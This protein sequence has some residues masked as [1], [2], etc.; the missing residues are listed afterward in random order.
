MV[1]TRSSSARPP[2]A[3]RLGGGFGAVRAIAALTA[4]AA[5]AGCSAETIVD[6]SVSQTV[7][8]D[9]HAM[10]ADEAVL[11]EHGA[12][13]FDLRAEPD[14][15]QFKDQLRC[16]GLDPFASTLEIVRLDAPGLESMLDFQL[17][18]APWPNGEWTP[19]A[20]LTDIVVDRGVVPFNDGAFTLWLEGL[21]VLDM[22]SLGDAPAYELR[23]SAQVPYSVDDLEVKLT[24]SL[25]F[26]SDSGACP[27]PQ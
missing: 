7:T 6:V 26:S 19:L 11:T 22:V 17:D 21:D 13:V 27:G 15:V 23:L 10:A 9:F 16:V 3:A 12:V 5:L 4:A 14:Y 1:S 20:T 24:L 2:R 25:A 8:V 18:I